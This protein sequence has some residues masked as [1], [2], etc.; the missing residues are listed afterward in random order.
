MHYDDF[1]FIQ[2]DS[3]TFM[4]IT[5]FEQMRSCGADSICRAW[6]EQIESYGLDNT[7]SID[8]ECIMVISDL[9]AK[10]ILLLYLVMEYTNYVRHYTLYLVHRKD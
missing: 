6:F 5:W 1:R 7:E 4:R 2:V 9:Y 8:K 10:H 3:M